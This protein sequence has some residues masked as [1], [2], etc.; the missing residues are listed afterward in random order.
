MVRQHGKI[1]SGLALALIA[2]LPLFPHA[3]LSSQKPQPATVSV[4]VI[5][6]DRDGRFADNLTPASFA[7]AVDGKPRQVLWVR[8]VSRGPGSLDEAG[9]RQ[10]SGTGA[11]RF[12]AEP[13][14]SILVVV[15]ETSIERGSERAV[16]QAAGALVD[17]F[18]LEDRIGVVRIPITRDSHVALT[19]ERVEVRAALRQVVGRAGRAGLSAVDALSMQPQPPV[20]DTNRA[21][22]DPVQ[23]TNPERERPPTEVERP[24]LASDE[25]TAPAAGFMASLEGVLKS[26]Q[27]FPARKVVAVFSGGLRP[28]GTARLDELAR[29]ALA[30][31]ATIFAF[32]LSGARE[33]RSSAP[34]SSALERLA[35]STGGSFTMVGKNADKS[36]ARVIPEMSAC[37]V[38][39]IEGATSDVDGKRHTLRVEASRQPLTIRA[40][41][42]FIP[43]ADLEDVVPPSPVPMPG[44]DS[45]DPTA[46]GKKIGA[47]KAGASGARTAA[48][49]ARDI[50][51]Q[52]LIARASGY[53]AGYEREYSMLV[54]EEKFVQSAGKRTQSLRSDLLLVRTPGAEGWVS[55]RDVFEV[56][57]KAVR[58][59]DDRLKRLFL[60]PGVEAQAQ[61]KQI[62]AESARYNIGQ[63]ERNINVPLFALKF[64]RSENLWRLRFRLAGK[65][66]V[67]GVAAS[68][69]SF[70]EEARPTLVALNKVDDVAAKGW[71]L[72]DPASGATIASRVE[73][74]LSASLIEFE[75]R[76]AR[77]AALGLWLPVEMTEVHSV[78]GSEGGR[79]RTVSVD[80]RATY[81]KFRRFQVT[82]AEQIKIPK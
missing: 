50:E 34:G 46:P 73:F 55:F 72:I 40:P 66:D 32:E 74:E 19:T 12:A 68:R 33:D 77:D 58:D 63:V 71:F 76:Y 29:A 9:R 75:V 23:A 27:P 28:G 65:Q 48:P 79:A 17:R 2:I 62:V 10:P 64:L 37:Y 3:F 15:D 4:E 49:S 80:A 16:I 60:D 26:L 5:A 20:T 70:E 47:S 81:S 6:L 54:A 31:H 11:L 1:G 67:G 61:L 56:D 8:H 52:R 35:T 21:A 53:V 45:A 25:G 13:A 41:E 78:Y 57:G 14:R 44:P 18:G 30:A 82:T 59:R 39:G 36:I 7:V 42:W 22:G 51:L 43:R 69:M 24:G 38:L